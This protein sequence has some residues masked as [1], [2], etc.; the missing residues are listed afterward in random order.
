MQL[1]LHV[2]FS[3]SKTSRS[4]PIIIDSTD[5]GQVKDWEVS[6]RNVLS[7]TFGNDVT[8]YYSPNYWSEV[9]ESLS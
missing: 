8:K 2:Y 4:Y 1:Y 9:Y 5:A 7:I 3:G 6:D